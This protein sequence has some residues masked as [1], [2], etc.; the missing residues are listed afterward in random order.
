MDNEATKN[1]I[2]TMDSIAEHIDEVDSYMLICGLH[3]D[4]FMMTFNGDT[5]E[6]QAML[7]A[8]VDKLSDDFDVVDYSHFLIQFN[9][10]ARRLMEHKY[11]SESE[12]EEEDL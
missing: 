8:I 7:R 3:G 11:G 9:M 10:F 5:D 2:A 12:L 1:L 6:M 4:E